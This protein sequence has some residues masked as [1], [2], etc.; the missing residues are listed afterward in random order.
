M[1]LPAPSAP[2][3]CSAVE[4]HSGQDAALRG[5]IL[6]TYAVQAM[7]AFADEGACSALAA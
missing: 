4:A 1:M 5:A 7:A 6:R 2:A 3:A